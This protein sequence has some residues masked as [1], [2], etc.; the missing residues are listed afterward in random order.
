MPADDT[1]MLSPYVLELLHDQM[2]RDQDVSATE[3]Q[4]EASWEFDYDGKERPALRLIRTA[5]DAE[6]VAV[7]WT[8]YFGFRDARWTGG[9]ADGGLDIVGAAVAG[10]VKMHGKP[11]GRPHLQKLHGAATGDV[12][13]MFFSLAGFTPH[14]LDYAAAVEM[15]L[16]TFDFQGEPYP[17]NQAALDLVNNRP[18]D[19][20]TVTTI[21]ATTGVPSEVASD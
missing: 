17:V 21:D 11:V 14:A 12:T 1:P 20:T 16:F 18:T 3:E 7:E 15:A 6:L 9:G 5:A 13:R 10:E 19:H 2:G 4:A 8:R